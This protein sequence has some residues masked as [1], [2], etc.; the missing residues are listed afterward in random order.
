M[1]AFVV[2]IRVN[3]F[4]RIHQNSVKLDG[5]GRVRI[6]QFDQFPSNSLEIADKSIKFGPHRIRMLDAHQILQPW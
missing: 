2:M 4:S 1:Q 3:E 6:L 5:F